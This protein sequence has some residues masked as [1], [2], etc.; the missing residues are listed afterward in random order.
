[1]RRPS[2][3][4]RSSRLPMAGRSGIPVGV[5]GKPLGLQGRG[6]RVRPDPDLGD[7]LPAG[8]VVSHGPRAHA[9]RRDQPPAARLAAGR[10]LRGR[11]RP[12]GR[13]SAARHRAGRARADVGLD[14]DAFWSADLLGREVVETD[15]TLVGVRR[16]RRRRRR[17]RLPRDRPAR[18]RRGAAAVRRRALEVTA[19][20]VV[21]HPI[22]GLLDPTR[23]WL[24]APCASTSSRCSRS[25]S[26]GRS[27]ASLLGKA[28]AAGLLD[29]R[30]ARPAPAGRRTATAPSTT[31][32]T[33]AAPGWCS[34]PSRSSPPSRSCTGRSPTRPRT[35]AA[36]PLAAGR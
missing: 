22:P 14:E 25:S 32:P 35:V 2:R 36:H 12:R 24:S 15:G 9:G 34:S 29:G 6:V 10:A 4:S 3:S 19:D 1:M 8:A 13:R 30:G 26:P 5:V 17:A 27:T 21:V 18:R 28:A 23:R 33:A 20:R 11:R 31:C 16:G 7:E